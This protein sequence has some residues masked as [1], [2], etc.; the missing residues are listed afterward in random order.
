VSRA[1]T[2]DRGGMRGRRVLLIGTFDPTMPRA[3]QWQRLLDR[4]GCEVEV[5]NIPSWDVD[6]ASKTERSAF[7]MLPPV[8]RALWTLSRHLLTCERPDLVVLLYPGHLDACILGPIAR[9]RRI[10]AVLDVF[11]SLYDTVVSD[12]GLQ[13]ERSLH[14]L[15]TRAVDVLACWS[16][17]LV[18][19]DTPE[20]ADF[21]AGF[22]HRSREHFPVLWIG[23]DESV[24]TPSP[25]P[26]DDA[27]ILWYLTYIPLHGF[28]TVARAAALLSGDGRR[29]R[30]VGNGQ[31]RA[32][33]EQLAAELQLDNVDFVDQIAE[34][35]LPG[36]IARASICLGVFGTSDKAQRVVPNKA[37][38]CA[39]VGRAVITAA[40]P[41]IRTAFGDAFVTVPAGDPG[42]LADAVRRLRGDA[43][44]QA[45][46]R[47]RAAFVDR[48]SDAALAQDLER[49]LAGVVRRKPAA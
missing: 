1:D 44:L 28:E 22:T 38:Q 25:D 40:S 41:A 47:A 46:Q 32:A 20:H 7:S 48:F 39:A 19:V 9:L 21:F 3:R 34:S 12:R 18:V 42:A 8:L 31:E 13:S 14:A 26:G 24:F 4:L 37:F 16:V 11:V 43:R 35:E 5:R 45:A 6:R 27:D 36:E 23:A 49:I 15:A 2:T 17:R 30:L 33:A 10:P 29:I